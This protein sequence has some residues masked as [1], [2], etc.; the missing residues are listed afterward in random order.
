MRQNKV[1]SARDVPGH[2]SGHTPERLPIGLTWE[3]YIEHFV[4]E[5][6]GWT[7]LADELV[8][9]AAGRADVP[10]DLQSVEKGLRRLARREHRTG[11]QYGRWMLRVFGVPPLVQDWIRWLAQYHSRFA[12]LPTSLRLE[13][14]RLWDRPPVSESGAAAWV[15]V[16]MASVLHRLADL[17]GCQQ[18]MNLAMAGAARAGVSATIEID[19]FAARLATDQG[20]RDDAAAL[21]AEAE[22]LLADGSLE[23]ADRLCYQARLLGQRAYHLTKPL[24]GDAED[25]HGALALFQQIE[26]DLSLPFVCFRRYAGL[27][28]CTWKLGDAAEG[29]RLA[30]LALDHA[31]DGGFIRFRVL[32]LNMLSRM[33]SADEAAELSARAARLARQLE[34]EDLSRRVRHRT[35]ARRE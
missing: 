6:G 3:A 24:P 23:R 30:R 20:R 13:Q 33:V 14:L 11:G 27:A 26:E 2:D 22:R 12:D 28:Y 32:A 25:L 17:D 21:L 10:L 15:H 8:R 31:G 7:A 19:L 4:E 1:T 5:L 18:R 34:D 35:R 16:A 9:R 29:A